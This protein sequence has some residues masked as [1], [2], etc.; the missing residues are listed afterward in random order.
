[1]KER[2]SRMTV[3]EIAERLFKEESLI[4]DVQKKGVMRFTFGERIESG[5]FPYFARIEKKNP[6]ESSDK[7]FIP[8][9]GVDARDQ[10]GVISSMLLE[11]HYL[12]R[13]LFEQALAERP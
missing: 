12:N 7:E 13:N 3:G 6:D 8:V 9:G 2:Q 11:W 10:N 5:A 4:L 1:M